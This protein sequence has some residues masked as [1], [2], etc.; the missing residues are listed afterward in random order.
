MAFADHPMA[1]GLEEPFLT[2]CNFPLQKDFSSGE[3]AHLTLCPQVLR[4]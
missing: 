2:S 4:D 3:L 1:T